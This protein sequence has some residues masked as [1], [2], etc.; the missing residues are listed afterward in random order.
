VYWT[1]ALTVSVATAGWLPK[2]LPLPVAVT[3]VAPLNVTVGP[4]CHVTAAKTVPAVKAS[5][6]MAVATE[7]ADRRI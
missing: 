5:T 7:N 1:V 3:D 2:P 4:E 6:A